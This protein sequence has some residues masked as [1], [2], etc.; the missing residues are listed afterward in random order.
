VNSVLGLA[1]FHTRAS[2]GSLSSR[3]DTLK[4]MVRLTLLRIS[5]IE[6]SQRT[7]ADNCNIIDM[8]KHS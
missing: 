6:E 3:R 7:V 8:K 1:V 2:V 5:E 4:E